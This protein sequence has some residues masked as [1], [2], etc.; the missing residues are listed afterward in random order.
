MSE[1]RLPDGHVCN[2]LCCD[3]RHGHIVYS[4]AAFDDPRE[5]DFEW[6][7]WG[8]VIE[9]CHYAPEAP[10]LSALWDSFSDERR[11]VL[12][13]ALPLGKT[14]DDFRCGYLV[15]LRPPQEAA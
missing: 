15:I 11:Q 5:W 8:W 10:P 2:A 12:L 13:S 6:A 4:T 14:V 3:G 7:T 1:L 9:D